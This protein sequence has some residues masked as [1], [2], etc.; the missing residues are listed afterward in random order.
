MNKKAKLNGPSKISAD[1]VEDIT[2][3]IICFGFVIFAFHLID[4]TLVLVGR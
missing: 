3:S 1:M 4:N 2:Y